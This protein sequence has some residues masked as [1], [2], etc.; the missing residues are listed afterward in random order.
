MTVQQANISDKPLFKHRGLLIDTSRNFLPVNIIKSIIKGMSATKMNVLHLHVTDSQSFPMEFPRVPMLHNFGSYSTKEIYTRSDVRNIIKF[1]KLRGVRI[2]IEIDGPS[3]SSSG[4]E[5]GPSYGLGNLSVC[6]NKQPWRQFCIQPPC[7]QIN[8]LNPNVYDVFEKVYQDLIE[9]VPKEE[10]IHMGGDEVFIPCWN[11]TEEII[12]NMKNRG[13]DLTQKSFLKIWSEFHIKNLDSW[14]KL[15]GKPDQVILW[16]SQLT[17]PEIIQEYLPKDKF[18]I[19]TWVEGDK[20]LNKDLLNLGYKI[21]VSTKNAWYLDHGF[22][23][24]TQ[25]YNWRTVYD[26]QILNND[27]VLGGEAC[28]WGEYVDE[29]SIGEFPFPI[30]T[31]LI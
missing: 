14:L 29:H 16:S 20:Q 18:I 1:A 23:G 3:H 21:I 11:S 13:L 28:M 24:K 31:K 10:T 9:V 2:I 15:K 12:D 6:I 19:Q 26:N 30:I 22:W 8:P 5:W 25:F 4:W 7:G 27:L 17:N